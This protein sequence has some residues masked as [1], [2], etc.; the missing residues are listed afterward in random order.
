[1]LRVSN[2]NYLISFNSK[3]I[4][5]IPSGRNV[6]NEKKVKESKNKCFYEILS[7]YM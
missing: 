7:K 3:F 2:I 1:M 5:K 6:Q 4:N